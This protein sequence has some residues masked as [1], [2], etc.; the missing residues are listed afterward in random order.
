MAL[1]HMVPRSAESK[2]TRTGD[3]PKIFSLAKAKRKR[4]GIIAKN[5]VNASKITPMQSAMANSPGSKE[6]SWNDA[7]R[8]TRKTG[9]ITK[10]V[11]KTSLKTFIR[12]E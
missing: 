9:P 2:V 4:Q 11:K 3:Q 8:I 10:P 1:K 12:S 5:K 7:Y 6:P